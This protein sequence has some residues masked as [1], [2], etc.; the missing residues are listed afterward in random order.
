MIRT[1]ILENQPLFCSGVVSA[2]KDNPDIRVVGKANN[3]RT[4]INLISDTPA[5]VALIGVNTPDL[6]G[7]SGI[8][9][10]LKTEHPNM[11]ILA[12]TNNTT[13]KTLESLCTVGIEGYI[14]KRYATREELENAIRKLAAGDIYTGAINGKIKSKFF[15]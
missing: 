12:I 6:M 4:F 13:I 8:V 10:R 11:K 3:S 9:R 5:D 14:G 7:Y 2:L 1:V 15:K